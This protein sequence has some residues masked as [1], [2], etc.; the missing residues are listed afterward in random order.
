LAGHLW[1]RCEFACG[2]RRAVH[3]LSHNVPTAANVHASYVF[4][5]EA[6]EL[7]LPIAQAEVTKDTAVRVDQLHSDFVC[8]ACHVK[9][10]GIH[11]RRF[12]APW[13]CKRELHRL[14]TP[15]GFRGGLWPAAQAMSSGYVLVHNQL[16]VAKEDAVPR[17]Q[18]PDLHFASC[19]KLTLQLH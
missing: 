7:S 15:L 6:V 2:F 17:Q 19:G 12:A 16:G 18:I 13:H 3:E 9:S 5:N 10:N 14:T 4:A 8:M 1:S 11:S